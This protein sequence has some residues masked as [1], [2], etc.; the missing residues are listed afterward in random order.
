MTAT[1]AILALLAVGSKSELALG[2]PPSAE[3]VEAVSPER[4]VAM[5]DARAWVSELDPRV[6]RARVLLERLD[7]LYPDDLDQMVVV[8]ERSWRASREN[9]HRI[10]A[11]EILEGAIAWA[12]AQP[13]AFRRRFSRA[14]SFYALARDDGMSHAEAIAAVKEFAQL[15][16]R[17]RGR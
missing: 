4:R 5:M 15:R 12:E 1:V 13:S 8:T 16:R 3:E 11:T 7:R 14:V 6:M 9:G 17:M 2:V 10:T